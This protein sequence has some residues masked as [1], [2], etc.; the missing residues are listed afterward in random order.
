MTALFNLSS[1]REKI[2]ALGILFSL[3]FW[4]YPEALVFASNGQQNLTQNQPLVFEVKNLNLQPEIKGLQLSEVE[5]NDPLVN[6]LKIYFLKH[7][8][9]LAEY[10]AEIIQLPQWQRSA[11]ISWVESNFCRRH[12]DNNCS[13]IGV[14]PGHKLW[15]KYETYLDWFKDMSALMEKPLYKDKYNTFQKMKGVYVQPGSA[16]WVNGATKK[17]N[18]L[19]KLTEESEMQRQ[20]LAEKYS[21]KLALATFPFIV[22]LEQ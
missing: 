18:E 16:N 7:N 2:T 17:Y 15:R 11:A 13:G 22:N 10:S 19:I 5:E 6:N 1:V 14:K 20:I 12:A 4:A 9:P 3:I 21:Q 8:S